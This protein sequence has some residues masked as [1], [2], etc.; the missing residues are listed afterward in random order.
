MIDDRAQGPFE[1]AGGSAFGDRASPPRSGV[2]GATWETACGSRSGWA[3]AALRQTN[4]IPPA[5]CLGL[6]KGHLEKTPHGVT[7]SAPN[8]A[9]SAAWWTAGTARPT[10]PRQKPVRQTKPILAEEAWAWIMDEGLLMIWNCKR[11]GRARQTK[12]ICHSEVP[13]LRPSA[14]GPND[15]TEAPE[16][17]RQTN[18]IR[19]A[20]AAPTPC[21]EGEKRLQAR[22]LLFLHK[23]FHIKHL[24]TLAPHR[25]RAS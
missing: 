19:P 10:R 7:T 13:P 3:C 6:A 23:A 11:L 9:N 21:H 14:S 17:L 4:P 24:R 22:L 2:A 25:S 18:P 16:A 1:G 15:R 20:V 12:P 5:M 8:K